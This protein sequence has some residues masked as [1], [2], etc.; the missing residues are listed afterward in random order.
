MEFDSKDT[1]VLTVYRPNILS[2]NQFLLQLEK[3]IVHYKSLKKELIC[4]GDFN[5]D[6]RSA[7]PIQNFM[8][9]KGFM[10][11]VEF[12]TTEGSTTLEDVYLS[13]SLQATVEK[14]THILQLS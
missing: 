8:I 7:G 3:V 13:T 14:N 6:A 1:V 10:Q 11:K 2:V 9:T 12:S 5:E 4:L